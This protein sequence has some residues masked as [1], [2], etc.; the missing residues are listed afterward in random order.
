M[1]AF[2][3]LSAKSMLFRRLDRE[4]NRTMQL[5]ILSQPASNY[6]R[7]CK[8]VTRNCCACRFYQN[9]MAANSSPENNQGCVQNQAHVDDGCGKVLRRAVQDS[10]GAFIAAGGKIEDL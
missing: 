6:F 10:L 9:R 1:L 7:A 4:P 3:K 2:F 8:L 5:S